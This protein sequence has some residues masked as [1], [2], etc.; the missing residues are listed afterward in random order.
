MPW[1]AI[2]AQLGRQTGSRRGDILSILIS[3]GS[4]AFIS[5]SLFIGVLY[6][7]AV[8]KRIARLRHYLVSGPSGTLFVHLADRCKAAQMILQL[9]LQA[10]VRLSTRPGWL[11]SLITAMENHG[12]WANAAN[13]IEARQKRVDA[14]FIAQSVAAVAAW[15]LA[16]V[17]DFSS[18]PGQMAS[19]SSSEWQI[20]MGSLWLW[21]VS[22][23]AY[24]DWEVD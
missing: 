16:I 21:I 12:W 10:P 13:D 4:P 3:I 14:V 24:L 19:A 2:F 23:S 15:L 7:R 5:S 22:K 18:L 11:S 8:H 1:L 9:F 20:C 17:G 6:Q